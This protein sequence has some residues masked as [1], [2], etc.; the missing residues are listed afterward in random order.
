MR[1]RRE[2]PEPVSHL[3]NVRIFNLPI[4]PTGHN[5]KQIAVGIDGRGNQRAQLSPG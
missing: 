3:N 4:G 5:F 2:E 1:G